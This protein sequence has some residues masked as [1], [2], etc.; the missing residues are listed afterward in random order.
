MMKIQDAIRLL[1]VSKLPNGERLYRVSDLFRLLKNTTET[2]FECQNIILTPFYFDGKRVMELYAHELFINLV[3]KPGF[4]TYIL[5]KTGRKKICDVPEKIQ[6]LHRNC[7]VEVPFEKPYISKERILRYM[8]YLVN[9]VNAEYQIN[10]AFGEFNPE[11]LWL[12][13]F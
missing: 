8:E 2:V 3:E 10:K 9:E 1:Q 6:Q 12:E 13:I 7:Y 11:N 5:K 4:E